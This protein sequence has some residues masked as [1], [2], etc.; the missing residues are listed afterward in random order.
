MV[1]FHHQSSISSGKDG[2]LNVGFIISLGGYSPRNNF[3]P[4]QRK[5]SQN[6]S[7]R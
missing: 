3:P 5:M 4:Y 7:G 2:I 6:K 1:C